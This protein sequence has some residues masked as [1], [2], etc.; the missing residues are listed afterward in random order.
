MTGVYLHNDMCLLECQVMVITGNSSNSFDA[1]CVCVC[2]VCVCH[3]CVCVCV[4]LFVC[5]FVCLCVCVC[6]C[7]P[8]VCVCVSCACVCVV[9]VIVKRPVLPPYLSLFFHQK[10]VC[11]STS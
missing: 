4:C 6:V 2:R 7:V 3:V 10:I 8:C 5:L 1:L 9:S 11:L